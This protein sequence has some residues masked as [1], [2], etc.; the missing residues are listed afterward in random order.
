[1]TTK[2]KRFRL[3]VDCSQVNPAFLANSVAGSIKTL[4]QGIAKA[5]ADAHP[6]VLTHVGDKTVGMFCV[7]MDFNEDPE[8]ESAQELRDELNRGLR[9]KAFNKIMG[10]A[11]VTVKVE[12][13]K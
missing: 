9:G 12:E 6:K 3:T 5:N 2:L 4:M 7:A 8:G 11:K 1:M 13:L 10:F